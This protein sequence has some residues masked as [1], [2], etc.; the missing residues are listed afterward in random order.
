MTSKNAQ[1]AGAN[2]YFPSDVYSTNH[3]LQTNHKALSIYLSRIYFSKA[4]RLFY[5]AL[6]VLCLILVTWTLVNFGHFPEEKWFVV[7]EVFISCMIIGEVVGR[8][9]MQGVHKFC[10][11]WLNVFDAVV[12]LLSIVVLLE[13]INS[14]T[15]TAD[16]EGLAGEVWLAIRTILQYLRLVVFIKNQQKA[17]VLALQVINFT[18]LA[19]PSSRKDP[20]T[21]MI[22]G[23]KLHYTDEF[24]E[25]DDLDSSKPNPVP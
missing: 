12:G 1:N 23:A 11:S 14:L 13:V 2:L 20:G 21:E 6:V 4:C 9:V 22:E 3:L 16:I 10:S 25:K 19:Q 5:V 8:I 7:L 18:E 15:F 17:Q 24:D